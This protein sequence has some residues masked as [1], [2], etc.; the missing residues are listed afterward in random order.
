MNAR[1]SKLRL[2][3]NRSVILGLLLV[4]AALTTLWI[5][6]APSELTLGSG[7]KIVYLHA[8]SIWAGMT[9]LTLA[10]LLG[11][12]LLWR[13]GTPH[14]E[15]WTRSIAW[16]AYGLFVLGFLLSLLA[17]QINWGGVFWQ[18]PRMLSN[19]RVAAVGLIALVLASWPVSARI[20]GA[21]WAA[22]AAF[23][24]GSTL[25]TPLLLHPGDPIQTATSRAIQIT[26]YGLFVLVLLEGGLLVLLL[27]ATP[28]AAGTRGGSEKGGRTITED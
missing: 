23:L 3:T 9:G 1:T 25:F 16:V 10:G 8:A 21:L 18:E 11:A 24:L 17:A 28:G 26:F 6:Y 14:L 7:I 22:F 20:K 15:R 5:W 12:L 27:Q 2:R 19:L 4:L 13:P